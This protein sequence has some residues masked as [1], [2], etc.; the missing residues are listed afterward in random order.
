[1]ASTPS[2]SPLKP[3][4]ILNGVSDC[5]HVIFLRRLLPSPLPRISENVNGRSPESQTSNMNSNVEDRGRRRRNEP[6]EK[7]ANKQI[8][9]YHVPEFGGEKKVYGGVN[10]HEGGASSH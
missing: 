1:M 6:K 9:Q 3:P 7:T 5:Y 2:I 8:H 10:R 4:H